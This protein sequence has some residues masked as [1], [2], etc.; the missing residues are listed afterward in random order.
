MATTTSLELPRARFARS[1]AL[2]AEMALITPAT[3][4]GQTRVART[5]PL[6]VAPTV[7]LKPKHPKD[8]KRGTG[9][10]RQGAG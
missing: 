6:S 5:L 8:F 9:T 1:F 7:A 10:P 4:E 2:G 3:V